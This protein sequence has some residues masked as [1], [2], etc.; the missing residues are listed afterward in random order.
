MR[1]DK[2][3]ASQTTLSRKEAA[4]AL[5]AGRVTLDGKAVRDPAMHVDPEKQEITLDNAVISYKK[6]LYIMLNKP[7]GYV[8]STDDPGAP[9]VLELLPDELRKREL[10]PCGRLDRY[11]TGL[12]ILTDDG[13]SAHYR[14][15]PKHHVE[16][17]YEFTCEK[18]LGRI[19]EL[20]AGV[21]IEGGYL[22]KPCKVE[23]LSEFEGRITLTEGKYHQ[24]KQ[25]LYAVGNKIVT[26]NR[27]SFGEILLDPALG[28]GQWRYLTDAE[29]ALFT[30]PPASAQ[31]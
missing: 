10:F 20:E 25:M 8:S 3:I 29:I 1:L 22:T 12:M 27:V 14:L 4:A 6:F 16:K 31:V 18:P 5:R 15:S 2:L 24:I 9:T 30:A 21:H 23:R 13:V 11:T 28:R 7:E 17:V 26:L 19:D